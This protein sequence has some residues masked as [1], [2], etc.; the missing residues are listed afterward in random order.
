MAKIPNNVIKIGRNQ[1]AGY[2]RGSMRHNK[3]FVYQ[4]SGVKTVSVHTSH[5]TVQG[6]ESP[7]TKS[8]IASAWKNAKQYLAQFGEVIKVDDYYYVEVTK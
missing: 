4:L 7:D 6:D 8:A 2:V 5:F 3:P 1:N